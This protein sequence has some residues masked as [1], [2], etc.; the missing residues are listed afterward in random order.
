MTYSESKSDSN[1]VINIVSNF[2]PTFF[3]SKS[4]SNSESE[5]DFSSV[6]V[7]L[8]ICIFLFHVCIPLNKAADGFLSI[9][10]TESIIMQA[11][12]A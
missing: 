3:E 1:F 2:A 12:Q 7:N 8:D 5:S 4:E 6:F 11:K 10:I 9:L